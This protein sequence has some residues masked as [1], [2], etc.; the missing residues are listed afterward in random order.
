MNAEVIY[1]PTQ[2]NPSVAG[3]LTSGKPMASTR[4][5]EADLVL[6]K[7]VTAWVCRS[8]G[9]HGPDA[10]DFTQDV[11]VRLFEGWDGILGKFEGRSSLNTY[12]A[13]VVNR[14]YLDGQVS[15]YGKFHSSAVAR[16]LGP[17]ALRL[18][19]LVYRDG[20]PFD[21][22]CGVLKTDPGVKESR[23][24]LHRIL[25]ML[26]VRQPRGDVPV[27][28]LDGP[29]APVAR[30]DLEKAQRQELAHRTFAAIRASLLRMAPQ[31][32]LILRML[33]GSSFTVA[34]VAR[35]LGLV[36]QAVYR[37][38][39]H[40]LAVVKADLLK[41]SIGAK[42]AQELLENLDWDEALHVDLAKET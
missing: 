35:Q 33:F 8:R 19:R 25:L 24:D 23:E 30:D 6:I 4:P 31:D 27:S 26:P 1:H 15:R 38:R 39:D 21:E 16:R 3:C 42:E 2:P 11:Y 22:A 28:E 37:R 12:L 18:E 14:I 17:A 9:L 32:R 36:Q 5:S 34:V 13:V 41:E 20:L 7:K 29:R 40:L 10:E